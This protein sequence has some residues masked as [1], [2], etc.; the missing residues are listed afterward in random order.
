[1]IRPFIL[2]TD[3]M[4]FTERTKAKR[5]LEEIMYENIGTQISD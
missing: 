2:H 3:T 5:N 4:H 1:V